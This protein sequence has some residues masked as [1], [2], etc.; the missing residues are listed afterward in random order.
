MLTLVGGSYYVAN[1][2]NKQATR[3]LRVM[4]S[5]GYT[6]AGVWTANIAGATGIIIAVAFLVWGIVYPES[7]SQAPGEN[8]VIGIIFFC[9]FAAVAIGLW[10]LTLFIDDHVQGKELNSL[11]RSK[12]VVSIPNGLKA[13]LGKRFEDAKVSDFVEKTYRITTRDFKIL[14]EAAEA[15]HRGVLTAAM[16]AELVAPLLARMLKRVKKSYDDTR[17]AH[18]AKFEVLDIDGPDETEG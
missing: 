6:T 8:D 13:E 14:R 3:L 16:K 15:E 17:A 12:E 11:L 2:A 4:G 1:P 18:A 9:L 5:G 10:R 7:W